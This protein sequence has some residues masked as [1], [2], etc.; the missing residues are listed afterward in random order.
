MSAA[1]WCRTMDN[2]S[3]LV[4]AW[5]NRCAEEWKCIQ[6]GSADSASHLRVCKFYRSACLSGRSAEGEGDI[7]SGAEML[8]LAAELAHHMASVLAASADAVV[9][10][11]A[12]LKAA[13]EC[14]DP[15]TGMIVLMGNLFKALLLQARAAKHW[16]RSAVSIRC[17][18]PLSSD[19]RAFPCCLARKLQAWAWCRDRCCCLHNAE[20]FLL[21]I[22]ADCAC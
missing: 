16:C 11:V 15:P 1:P 22:G 6:A 12:A 10:G 5:S 20:V 3:L 8:G 9:R 17:L 21:Q 13:V 7:S 4:V 14:G 18:H 19:A 2:L